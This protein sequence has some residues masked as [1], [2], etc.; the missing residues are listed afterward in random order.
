LKEELNKLSVPIVV[1]IDELDRVEDNEI[2]SMAQ[3]VS[4]VIDFPSISYLL[5]Y[6]SE[7]VI[8]A[9]G[10]GNGQ[11]NEER[12][13]AYLEKIVQL[14][15]PLPYTL[16]EEIKTFLIVELEQISSHAYLPP[17]WKEDSRFE[18]LI[19][20][21]IPEIIQNLRDVNRNYAAIA[22]HS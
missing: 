6:D 16:P 10:N 18:D 3:L 4:S 22:A 9:L 5:A 21:L 14:Q 1:L 11:A 13:R 8:Q 17:N 15:I 12:G 7:R 2:R 19:N 20:I